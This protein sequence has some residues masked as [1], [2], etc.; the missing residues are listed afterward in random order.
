MTEDTFSDCYGDP[1]TRR[2][3]KKPRPSP[4]PAPP[5]GAFG[6][7]AGQPTRASIAALSRGILFFSRQEGR[8]DHAAPHQLQRG[9]LGAARPVPLRV[10]LRGGS[11]RANRF[12]RRARQPAR[13]R[14]VGDAAPRPRPGPPR[15][16]AAPRRA[17]G[18]RA[19]RPSPNAPRAR[20]NR[21]SG[22][23]YITTRITQ[24]R[25]APRA[26]PARRAGSSRCR[27]RSA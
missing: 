27:S 20:G 21:L 10:H 18:A 11:V 9:A 25:A 7:P 3:P 24:A 26:S 13:A 15:A 12:D 16:R 22:R 6:T 4:T 19:W 8:G 5:T 2:R 1:G 23:Q 14:A 17:P